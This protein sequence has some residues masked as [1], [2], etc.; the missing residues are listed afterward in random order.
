MTTYVVQ[1]LLAG[2]IVIAILVA[3]LLLILIA[4]V[5]LQE[6][7]RR[8]FHWAA[9]GVSRIGGFSSSP[10]IHPQ[11]IFPPSLHR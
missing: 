8:A 6:G 9:T 7:A 5:L 3:T 4:I 10:S 2:I 1:E 11:P